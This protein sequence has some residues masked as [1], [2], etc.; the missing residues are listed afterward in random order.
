MLCPYSNK[1][2]FT[3][4]ISLYIY[5]HSLL[6]RFFK[7]YFFQKSKFR[8]REICNYYFLV[9]I[10]DENM[11]IWYLKGTEIRTPEMRTLLHISYFD[12]S[13][14]TWIY[15]PRGETLNFALVSYNKP[16]NECK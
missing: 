14:F 16:K 15:R 6:N 7:I 11:R 1:D 10:L 13:I 5:A 8:Y 2:V 4:Y 9:L 3:S 12:A